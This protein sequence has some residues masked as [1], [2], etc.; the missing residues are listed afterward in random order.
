M[1]FM[2]LL[3]ADRTTEEGR[4]PDR[5]DLEIMGKYNEE[6]VKAGVLLDATGL[7]P[8]SKG[9]KVTFAGGKPQVTDG[10]FAE[11]KDLLAGYWMIQ[12]NSKEEAI[13]WAKR[14]PFHILPQEGRPGPEI[15][16]RQIFEISDFPDVPAD[17]ARM[18]EGFASQRAVQHR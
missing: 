17:V 3:K 1:R 15:E 5:R 13:E 16:I 11:T 10:P 4:L 2:M 12:V 6:M 9:A 18:E 7:Q 8:T 14:V